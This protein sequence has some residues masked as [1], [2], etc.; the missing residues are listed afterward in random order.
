[1]GQG[2]SLPDRPQSEYDMDKPRRGYCVIINRDKDKQRTH[3]IQDVMALQ[4]L[5][6]HLG[7]TVIQQENISL[8]AVRKLL[9]IMASTDHT[10]SCCLVWIMLSHDSEG[11][12]TS[13]DGKNLD[14]KELYDSFSA[15]N[16]PTLN[17]KPK[18]FFLFDSQPQRGQQ[19]NA[20]E[21][22]LPDMITVHSTSPSESERSSCIQTF[23]RVLRDENHQKEEFKQQLTTVWNQLTEIQEVSSLTSDNCLTKSLY[24]YP[25]Q[26]RSVR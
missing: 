16:C 20:F 8:P 22:P 18:I 14:E 10:D 4:E 17:G 23:A 21:R 13:S 26:L 3:S 5:F 7:F 19:K 12:I 25:K 15:Q 11:R 2:Q 9:H 24:L 1:M 6:D